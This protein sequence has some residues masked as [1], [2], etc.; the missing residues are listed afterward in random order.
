MADVL[1]QNAGVKRIKSDI[2]KRLIGGFDLHQG[3]LKVYFKSAKNKKAL[4]G[5]VA[6]EIEYVVKFDSD[7]DALDLM[8]HPAFKSLWFNFS[9]QDLVIGSDTYNTYLKPYMKKKE[10]VN[11]GKVSGFVQRLAESANGGDETSKQWMAEIAAMIR[12]S[13]PRFKKPKTEA[14]TGPIIESSQPKLTKSQESTYGDTLDEIGN[15]VEDAVDDLLTAYGIKQN[16]LIL[17]LTRSQEE[18]VNNVRTVFWDFLAE[19][20][21]PFEIVA[22]VDPEVTRDGWDALL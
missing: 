1:D 3:T 18:F 17:G 12:E 7:A 10:S 4:G 2:D 9:G 6:N 16:S 19:T 22:M 15:T 13:A 21:S 14:T 11:Y 5:F 20:Y 8:S